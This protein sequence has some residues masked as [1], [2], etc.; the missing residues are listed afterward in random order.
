MTTNRLLALIIGAYVMTGCATLTHVTS[1][2]SNY[3]GMV[4]HADAEMV[5][6]D[7][8]GFLAEQLPPAKTTFSLDPMEDYFHYTLLENLGEQGFGVVVHAPEE[9]HEAI[10]LRYAVSPVESGVVVR[11]KFQGKEVSGFYGR[12]SNGGLSF[13]NIYAVREAIK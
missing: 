3:I 13:N 9:E 7:M 1:Q 4:S 2:Q 10:A 12:A 8:A 6:K 11:M 5:T